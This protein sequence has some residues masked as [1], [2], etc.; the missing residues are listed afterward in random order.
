MNVNVKGAPRTDCLFL[1]ID[2]IYITLATGNGL[3]LM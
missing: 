1:L 2:G 3:D